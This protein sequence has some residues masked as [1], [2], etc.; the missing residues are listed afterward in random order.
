MHEGPCEAHYEQETKGWNSA[1]YLGHGS[2]GSPPQEGCLSSPQ[3]N[4]LLTNGDG[5]RGTVAPLQHQRLSQAPATLLGWGIPLEQIQQFL[6]HAKVKTR[7]VDAASTPDR[8]QGTRELR[9]RS[10]NNLTHSIALRCNSRVARSR[11]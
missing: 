9:S 7:L 5:E 3:E 6:E 8:Y 11:T 10:D 1:A 2:L 4:F